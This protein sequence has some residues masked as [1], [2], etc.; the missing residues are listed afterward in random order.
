MTRGMKG[1]KDSDLS[2]ST[3][4]FVTAP[5]NRYDADMFLIFC[6]IQKT[7]GMTVQRYIR[8]CLGPTLMTRALWRI[9]ILAVISALASTVT[10]PRRRPT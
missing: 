7:A 4:S 8:K 1:E 2:E 3:T 5:T 10:C 9:D 6:H